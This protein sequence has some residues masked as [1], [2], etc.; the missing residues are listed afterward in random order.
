[1]AVRDLHPNPSTRELRSAWKHGCLIC[2]NSK[3]NRNTERRAFKFDGK[4]YRNELFEC[5]G[6][7]LK[8]IP[9]QWPTALIIA[10]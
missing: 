6:G 4:C 2:E 9:A 1:M 3:T 5:L 7:L 8:D 10:R